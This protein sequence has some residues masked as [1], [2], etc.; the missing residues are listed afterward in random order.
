[1]MMEETFKIGT[2]GKPHGV[3]GEMAFHFDDDVF[4]RVD[5]DYLFLK[6]DGLLVPFF[7]DEYR[8]RSDE[9]AL[10]TFSGIDSEEK[11]A[12]L[13]GCDVYFPRSLAD[14]DGDAE[15]VSKAEIVGY[16]IINEADG[17]AIGTV[18]A[19][20]DSTLNTLFEV[21]TREGN[22]ILLPVNDDLIKDVDRE[23]RTITM[24]I[25]EGILS[26]NKEQ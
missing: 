17:Q 22:K 1:M 7:I 26:L 20:D 16:E 19:V 12:E 18:E 24:I 4:D 25:P 11:A 8:F 6:I 14:S 5:A 2:L 21:T 3:K 23:S 9:T 10:M 15:T 13:T